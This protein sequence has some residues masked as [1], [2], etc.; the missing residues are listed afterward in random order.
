[1]IFLVITILSCTFFVRSRE[2]DFQFNSIRIECIISNSDTSNNVTIQLAQLAVDGLLQN[3]GVQN[4][5]INQSS[6]V[7]GK[8]NILEAASSNLLQILDFTSRC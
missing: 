2:E 8:C 5:I 1:M 7:S 6:T 3:E 4:I